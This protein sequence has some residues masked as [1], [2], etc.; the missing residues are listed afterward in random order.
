MVRPVVGSFSAGGTGAKSFGRSRERIFTRSPSVFARETST[1][2]CARGRDAKIGASEID[3]APPEI[4]QSEWPSAIWSAA[5]VVVWI[6]VAQ[7]R[8][9]VWA[10]TLRGS[11]VR[12][13]I[14]RPMSVTVDDGIT[15]PKTTRVELPRRD[16]AAH[17]ELV[18]DERAEVHRGEVLEVGARL[19][20]RR[21]EPRDDRG[22]ATGRK[23][24][25]HAH[26]GR[27]LIRESVGC[28]RLIYW[29]WRTASTLAWTAPGR[30]R[31]SV[32]ACV[33]LRRPPG[34]DEH[35]AM[36]RSRELKPLSSEHHQ[37]LLVAFQ[38][39]KG[40]A[41]H[42]ESAG[43][44]KDLPGLLAL[45]RRFEEQLLRTHARAEEDLLGR[46]IRR[47]TWRGSAPSTPR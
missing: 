6:E 34:P 1:S 41:G 32:R 15:C 40:L 2:A 12:S 7:A 45:A 19:D 26:G 27:S 29:S 24:T 8:E 33:P 35:R 47:P 3:S 43:A 9:T 17:D 11:W 30:T 38:L 37:A 46:F 44:P 13:T 22:A 5:S 21:A 39:K 14:S 16:P 25:V 23:G 20:E 36:K 42:A 28:S 10:C 31:A 4:A 18:H